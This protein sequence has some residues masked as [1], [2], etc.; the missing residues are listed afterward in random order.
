MILNRLMD[1]SI[2]VY[3]LWGVGALGLLLKIIAGTYIG[4]LV[5]ESE[6]MATTR[7]KSL[8]VMR[9]KYENGRSLGIRN[10]SGEA[11]AG[12]QVRKMRLIGLPFDFYVR[13]GQTFCFITWMIMAGA[14]LFYDNTW[15]GSPEMIEF[16]SYGVIVCAFLLALE[17]IFLIN[18]K[19]EI[20]K[21]NIRDYLE[22]L[23]PVREEKIRQSA[24]QYIQSVKNVAESES[25][26]SSE[27]ADGGGDK[28]LKQKKLTNIKSVYDARA[29]NEAAK[30]T[31][32]EP[33]NEE[34]LN[35]FLKEFFS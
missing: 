35:S 26:A 19:V 7:R 20:L 28:T 4:K 18:N 21:A 6:N 23:T 17:N 34:V 27:C 10:G 25:A 32:A 29:Q 15:R 24:K 13:S 2:G 3:I 9:Q 12:K 14:F 16:M 22:N 8:R 33:G 31:E 1:L 11:F 30:A 5:R